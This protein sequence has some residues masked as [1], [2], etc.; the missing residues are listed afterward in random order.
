MRRVRARVVPIFRTPSRVGDLRHSGPGSNDKSLRS[1]LRAPNPCRSPALTIKT[2]LLSISALL[3]APEPNDPQDAVVASQYKK[4]YKMW[5]STAKFWT[6]SAW[7]AALMAALL[8]VPTCAA[9]R[10]H[11]AG[12]TCCRHLAT[13]SLA[14]MPRAG[15]AMAP[16]AGGGDSEEGK[17]GQ[18]VDMG[19][20][21]DAAARALRAKGGNV[22]QALELLFSSG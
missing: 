14:R 19:F 21:R 5:V 15:Y 3:S 9:L 18:L 4:E 22:E 2:A 10:A 11:W 6:E 20:S 7:R 1:D 8:S 12:L 17:I 16:A 13:L